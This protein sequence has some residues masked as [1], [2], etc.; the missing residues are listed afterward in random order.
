MIAT[1]STGITSATLASSI[2]LRLRHLAARV[3]A[4]GPNPLFQ[5]MCELSG[6][7]AALARFEAYAALDADFIR[8]HGADKLPPNIR[9]VK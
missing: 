6:S 2:A 3:H 4:L 5:M 1:G 9:I 8:S 7:S